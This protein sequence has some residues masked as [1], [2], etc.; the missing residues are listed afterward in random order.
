MRMRRP[1]HSNIT[2]Y[3]IRSNTAFV[4]RE[5]MHQS[6][7]L[8]SS[9]SFSLVPAYT[10]GY[11]ILVLSC[12]S[13]TIITSIMQ[14]IKSP[15]HTRRS[16]LGRRFHANLEMVGNAIS[17]SLEQPFNPTSSIRDKLRDGGERLVKF[18]SFGLASSKGGWMNHMWHLM[19]DGESYA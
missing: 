2:P 11:G 8:S 1:T 6:Y 19:R 9:I 5:T 17:Y 4:L 15:A 12:I 18:L 10:N 13:H 16:N 7:P 14:C 3:I